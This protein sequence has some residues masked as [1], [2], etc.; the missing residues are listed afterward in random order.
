MNK[1][2]IQICQRYEDKNM[3]FGYIQERVKRKMNCV[4]VAEGRVGLQAS[5]RFHIESKLSFHFDLLK[6]E[7]QQE[8]FQMDS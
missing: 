4:G 3:L 5:W 2:E 6:S 8:V 7:A 1:E